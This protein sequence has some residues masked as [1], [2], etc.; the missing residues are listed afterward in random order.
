MTPWCQLEQV[1]KP[2][3]TQISIGVVR[4][5]AFSLRYK[6]QHITSAATFWFELL[7]A[8]FLTMK[9]SRCT[10]A[11]VVTRNIPMVICFNF[12]AIVAFFALSTAAFQVNQHTKTSVVLNAWSL[13]NDGSFAFRSWYNEYNPTARVT[14]YNE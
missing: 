8:C 7:L 1:G 3:P 6:F 5:L 2:R 13:P 10:E 12:F 4:I 9:S 14:V 11:N